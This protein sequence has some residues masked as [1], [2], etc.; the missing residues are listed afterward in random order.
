MDDNNMT[1]DRTAGDVI[2]PFSMT[3][4]STSLNTYIMQVEPRKLTPPC[5]FIVNTSFFMRLFE[6][7][8][9]FCLFVFLNDRSVREYSRRVELFAQLLT[10]AHKE[11][12]STCSLFFLFVFIH[13]LFLLFIRTR[14]GVYITS[15][16]LPEDAS[17]C[18]VRMPAEV[19]LGMQFWGL[20][21]KKTKS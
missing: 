19:E 12:G 10:V 17:V 5:F 16:E 18:C 11:F 3:S 7:M 1:D 8:A 13:Y 21:W 15:P 6:V 2:R 9:Q 4:V 14:R 20:K